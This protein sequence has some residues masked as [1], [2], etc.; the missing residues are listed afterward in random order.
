MPDGK[1]KQAVE[2]YFAELRLVRGSGGATDERSLYVPLANLLNTV[3]GTL[4]PKVFCVQELADQGAGHPYFGLYATQQVQKGKLKS[5]QK[6]EHGVIE[7]KLIEDHAWL[8]VASDQVASYWQGHQQVLVTNT[9]DFILVGEDALAGKDDWK[10]TDCQL[11]LQARYAIGG[12]AGFRQRGW[13]PVA[14]FC[15]VWGTLSTRIAQAYHLISL[16][17]AALIS[18]TL[19]A[20]CGM[21]P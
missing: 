16:T 21:Q 6:P 20:A 2:A 3:S 1:L 14:L 10:L 11:P 18:N 17:R 15:F 19:L 7:V 12:A 13:Q 5:G 8:T 4:R 9:R